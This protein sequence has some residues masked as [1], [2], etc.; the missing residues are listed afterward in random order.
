MAVSLT[1]TIRDLHRRRARERRGLTLVEGVRLLEEALAAG[2]PLRG[3]A[4]APAL[5]GTPRG[6]ALKA[7]LLHRGVALGEVT[8]EELRKLADTEHPQGVVAV[9]EVHRLDLVDLPAGPGSVL[10]VLDA[11][12]DPGNVGALARA[13][14][15]L[16][17]AGLVT[18]PGTAE[19]ESPKALRGSMGALFRL[20]AAHATLERFTEWAAASGFALWVAAAG[21]APVAPA[22][23]GLR[24]ALV[25][26]NEGAG[27]G[28]ELSARA[29][30]T[31]AVPLRAGVES[32]NV[33]VAGGILLYEVTRDR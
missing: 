26:G 16:G 18:L 25:L 2:I 4:V 7:A 13:A 29:A 14:L 15:G 27:V 6:R 28:A 21:G 8:D 30:R 19:L 12:Q 5:E 3:A 31:V 22:P 9:A 33:A 32:L 20:P 10:L 23:A 1:S 24:L 11:V 17:A